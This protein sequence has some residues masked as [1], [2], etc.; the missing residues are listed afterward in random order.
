M[1]VL[2]RFPRG[3]LDLVGSISQGK[4]PPQYR[5]EVLPT[6]EMGELY[7]A[8]TLGT[9]GIDFL[10]SAAGTSQ[11]IVVPQNEVW[12]VRAFSIYQLSLGG[13]ARF[14]RWQVQ[15]SGFPKSSSVGV[16]SQKDVILWTSRKL[17]TTIAADGDSDAFVFPVPLALHAGA[18]LNW[19]IVQRDASAARTT[20]VRVAM[21]IL[22]T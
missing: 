6:L 22:K 12:L 5:D 16:V 7:L 4:A 9:A 20:L 2:N 21:H 15:A 14:E 17:D 13:V 1:S 3:F 18:S 11:N 8:Q 19:R 10:H